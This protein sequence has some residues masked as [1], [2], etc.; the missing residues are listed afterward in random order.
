[1]DTDSIDSL[2]T[3]SHWIVPWPPHSIHH[4]NSGVDVI[5]EYHVGIH[6]IELVEF[7]TEAQKG[8]AQIPSFDRIGI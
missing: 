5:R 7:F 8:L 3:Q 2:I 4:G 1:M 6:Q